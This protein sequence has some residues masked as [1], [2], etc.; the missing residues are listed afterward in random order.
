[1]DN[2]LRMMG[3]PTMGSSMPESVPQLVQLFV[4]GIDM[5][6]E[7]LNIQSIISWLYSPMQPFGT[8]FGGK[9]AECIIKEGGY[10]NEKCQEL[11][12]EYIDGKHS[13]HNEEEDKE[14]TEKEKVVRDAREKA[15]REQ[16][17]K[18]YLPKFEVGENSNIKTVRLTSYLNS[19]SNWASTRSHLLRDKPGNEGWLN[20]LECLADMCDTFNLLLDSSKMGEV[21]DWKQ[22][23]NWISTLYKG[24]Q[25]M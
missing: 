14:L 3:Q 4:L 8:F 6:K 20:Q 13:F 25:F 18:N 19:L 1:M 21:V 24:E 16:L 12:R 7:P 23:E 10:R 15:Q 5:M 9:L 11:V 2:W 22:V 17:V